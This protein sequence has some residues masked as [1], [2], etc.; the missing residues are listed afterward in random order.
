MTPLWRRPPRASGA[1]LAIALCL[2]STAAP[3][4]ATASLAPSVTSSA[5]GAVTAPLLAGPASRSRNDSAVVPW[6]RAAQLAVGGIGSSAAAGTVILTVRVTD[7][8][9]SP[10]ALDGR[11]TIAF[12]GP[13]GAQ[14]Q[15]AVTH[16]GALAFTAPKKILLAAPSSPT[17]GFVVTS[18]DDMEPSQHCAPVSSMRVTLPNGAGSFYVGDLRA[19]FPYQLCKGSPFG[20]PEP[21]PD[22]NV[23]S[24]VSD[25]VAS[26]YA[27]PWPSCLAVQLHLAVGEEGAAAGAA[28]YTATLTN[29]ST[30]SCTLDGYPELKLEN[31]AGQVVVRFTDGRSAGTLPPPPRPR[32][33]SM[34]NGG[35]A[36]F[37]FSAGDYQPTANGG[38]GAPCPGSTVLVVALPQGG[39]ALL[40]RRPFQLCLGGG[41]G[42]FTAPAG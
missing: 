36:Q 9:S 32:P 33:V 28:G 35:A 5:V 22:A 20:S 26:G 23:S 39:G 18:A 10:C 41:V 19:R 38:R 31:R 12:V 37:V 7:I 6:C 17:A 8:S 2:A 3:Q 42:A 40:D 11:P 30:A 27:P 25:Y 29:R 34:P 21:E 14:V 16:S 4:P 1:A 24:V 15:T 13:T